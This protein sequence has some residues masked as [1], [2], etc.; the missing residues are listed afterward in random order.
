MWIIL[1]TNYVRVLNAKH[2]PASRKCPRSSFSE[3]TSRFLLLI[4]MVLCMQT[5]NSVTQLGSVRKT[6]VILD[7]NFPGYT[8]VWFE[9]QNTRQRL[10]SAREAGIFLVYLYVALLKENIPILLCTYYVHKIQFWRSN[11]K[12]K[13]VFSILVSII[14]VSLKKN[15]LWL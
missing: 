3:Q 11:Y 6:T 9:K 15:V 4:L 14:M 10:G 7:A 8:Q 13:N 2:A 5:S 12:I 1:D